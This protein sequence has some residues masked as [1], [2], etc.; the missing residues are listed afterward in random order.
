VRRKDVVHRVAMP[1]AAVLLLA[2]GCV[3]G[4]IRISQVE[5]RQSGDGPL[6]ACVQGNLPQEVKV[7]GDKDPDRLPRSYNDHLTLTRK[8]VENGAELICWPETMLFGG[9]TREGLIRGN[10]D[11]LAR[12]FKDG[13]PSEALLESPWYTGN[14]RARIAHEFKVPMLVGAITDIPPEEQIH[15]WKDYSG[16]RRSYNTALL[17]NAQGR[18][19][20]SYDKRYLVPGGEYV[21]HEGFEIFGWAP[22]RDIVE[23]YSQGLQGYTAR[24]EPGLRP[25]TFRFPGKTERLNGRQWAFTSTICYEYAWPGCYIELHEAAERYPDFHVNISNEGWFKRSAELDQAVD[26]CRLRCIESRVPMIRATNTGITCSIDACGRVL[27]VLEVGGDDRE[28]Q[29]LM[30]A[31]PA[32]LDDPLP[33][34][35][36]ALVNRSLGWFSL[37]VIGAVFLKMVAGNI[38]ERNRRRR[39][40]MSEEGARKQ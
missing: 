1:A 6:V 9:T 15:D 8:G 33:P 2:L 25:T 30:L 24:I 32:V 27:G 17:F 23:G 16:G 31:Q 13:V 36:V 19:V 11:V 28:V 4:A 22:I 10:P 14:L 5:A 26:F 3:Y 29:G 37:L 39:V 34:M 7:R 21:P 12:H 35:F 18:P 20:A 40:K 38:Q